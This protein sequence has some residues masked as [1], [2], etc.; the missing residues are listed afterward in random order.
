MPT[1]TDTNI[2][3]WSADYQTL[4]ASSANVPKTA[5]LILGLMAEQ[6]QNIKS[7]MRAEST[8][9]QWE[10]WGLTATPVATPSATSTRF[11]IPGNVLTSASPGG[12]VE[13]HRSVRVFGT[14][15]GGASPAQGYIRSVIA[16]NPTVFVVQF[17]GGYRVETTDTVTE[18]F[19]G[20][21]TYFSGGLHH[22]YQLGTATSTNPGTTVAVTFPTEEADVAYQPFLQPLDTTG[23]GPFTDAMFI[24][25]IPT[26]ARTTTGFTF[27]VGA[28]P[29]A[30]CTVVF[31][32]MIIR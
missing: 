1:L 18:M 9:K 13:I 28:T 19:F 8:L 31:Y 2:T 4:G 15:A 10:R 25:K 32:W 22:F 7:V 21:D 26:A 11:S 30:G 14:F 24:T 6:L 23:A 12:P 5:D 17:T 20:G 16:T 3:T 29:L 27:T